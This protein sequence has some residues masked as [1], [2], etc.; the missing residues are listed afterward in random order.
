M[1]PP[2]LAPRF[3]SPRA[4]AWCATLADRRQ[5]GAQAVTGALMQTYLKAVGVSMRSRM[6]ALSVEGALP[7]EVTE[8]V[9]GLGQRLSTLSPI[10]ACYRLGTLYT[11]LQAPNLRAANGAY[12]TP[13]AVAQKL[14]DQATATGV[15]WSTARVWDPACGS[16]VFLLAVVERMA[17]AQ[18]SLDLATLASRLHGMEQD[19]VAA[20]LADQ[21]LAVQLAALSQAQGIEVATLVQV[22]NTLTDAP[23]RTYDLVIGNP[24][25]GRLTLTPALRDRYARSLFGHANL[26]GLFTDLALRHLDRQGV[27]AFV[28]PTSFLGGQYFCA[29]RQLL[30]T[31]APPTQLTFL[32]DRQGVFEDVLQETL[33]T[34]YRFGDAA[35]EVQVHQLIFTDERTLAQTAL[36]TTAAPKDGT[37]WLFPRQAEDA[38]LLQ[39]AAQMPDRLTDLGYRVSTGPLV[40][41]R[42]KAQLRV[43]PETGTFPIVWAD[44]VKAGQLDLD[45]AQRVQGRHVHVGTQRHLL[46]RTAGVV[47]QR[48]TAKEQPRRLV[49]AVLPPSLIEAHGGVVVE[50][51]LNLLLPERP[52]ALAPELLAW[53]LGTA[54]M[55]RLF[56]CVSGS[57]AV[58]AYELQAVPLPPQAWLESLGQAMADGLSDADAQA[59]LAAYY[60]P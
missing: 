50:N 60:E 39:R 30:A 41:N 36:G 40:W 8:E 45:A 38:R 9:V 51:H 42:H 3:R 28:T 10:E 11:G 25:Y 17:A 46:T 55:D 49:A 44:A 24:P 18:P 4:L 23:D 26:Y 58:S 56:R 52:S 7:T 35:H 15:D 43:V 13:V 20:A 37:P 53:L 16:G 12:Y 22:G 19:P 31:L 34:T 14:V 47:L 6:T 59:R 33:L 57:V 29:L 54:V 5:A 21:F 48:T 32:A 2:S 1:T 27:L